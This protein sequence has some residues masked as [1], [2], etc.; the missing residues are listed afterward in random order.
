MSAEWKPVFDR[1]NPEW[2]KD[3]FARARPA[4]ELP[5]EILAEFPKTSRVHGTRKS[6]TKAQVAIRLPQDVVD[7]FK[8]AGPGWH[9][10]IEAILRK[11]AGL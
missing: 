5:A 3:D 9:D 4:S 2:T 6:P 11:A 8:A 10:R 7:H 1:D